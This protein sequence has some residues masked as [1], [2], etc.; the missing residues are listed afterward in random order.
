[1]AR[2]LQPHPTGNP[3]RVAVAAD[4]PGFR[5]AARELLAG[6]GYHVV[7][8]ASSAAAALDVVERHAPEGV[9]LEVSLG[10]AARLGGGA[11]L[12]R[13]R[14]EL[15]GVLASADV[16]DPEMIARCGARGF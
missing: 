7:A 10:G 2:S 9:L 16:Q 15:A 4:H 11:R 8:D 14:P 6:R 1:M 3:P 12:A 13:S 5:D